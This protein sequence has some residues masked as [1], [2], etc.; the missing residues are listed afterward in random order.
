MFCCY[1]FLFN[2]VVDMWFWRCCKMIENA[3][4]PV[5]DSYQNQC[6][7][8][9]MKTWLQDKPVTKWQREKKMWGQ[10]KRLVQKSARGCTSKWSLDFEPVLCLFCTLWLCRTVA[11]VRLQRGTRDKLDLR[12]ERRC[13]ATS[14][15]GEESHA[16]IAETSYFSSTFQH[17]F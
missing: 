4:L 9:Y 13:T 14:T 3:K 7:Y 5:P 12:V 17:G 10:K 16:F 2:P 8:I 11:A 15:V 6:L 1:F